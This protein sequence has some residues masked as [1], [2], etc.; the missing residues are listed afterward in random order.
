MEHDQLFERLWS[1]AAAMEEWTAAVAGGVTSFMEMPNT[2]PPVFTQEL[3]EQKYEIG[4]Q[5]A[6]ANYS[7]YM[8]TSNDNLDEIL[9]TNPYI[10]TLDEIIRSIKDAV[11]TSK[12]TEALS[13]C[14]KYLPS[15]LLQ[16]YY[17]A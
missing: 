16:T 12:Y 1:G 3:L 4:K 2:N 17:K 5:T 9:K 10:S 7:F 8:G 14:K 11:E 13:L 15:H 6:L